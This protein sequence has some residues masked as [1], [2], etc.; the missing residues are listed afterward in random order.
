MRRN[1]RW[2]SLLCLAGILLGLAGCGSRPVSILDEGADRF[3]QGKTVEDYSLRNSGD[4]LD[5]L[6]DNYSGSFY[7]PSE[8]E[9]SDDEYEE[10]KQEQQG[11]PSWTDDIPTVRSRD[12]LVELVYRKYAEPATDLRFNVDGGYLP[13]LSDELFYVYCMIE[14]KDPIVGTGVKSW[15]WW[16]Q[17][18]EY[19]L[20]I[21]YAFPLDELTRMRTEARAKAGEVAR[22]LEKP[23]MSDYE[24]VVAVNEYL[25]DTVYYPPNEPYADVTHSAYG[26]LI[27]GCAVCEG[28]ACACQAILKEMNGACDLVIGPCT[29]GEYHA[30]NLAMVDGN[31]YQLDVT[32][33]DGS[34]QRDAYLLVT[35]AYMRQSRS[36]DYALYPSTP[37]YPY[38]P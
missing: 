12:E 20:G 23:G 2:I 31:W 24:R 29:N 15:L 7:S 9:L 28:Y 6:I 17:G 35:D 4:L 37:A 34:N 18:N 27:D 19:Y 16:N 10:K 26:A 8:T 13:D 1:R 21:E 25:C 22:K 38:T 33:N 32:W 30:W 3:S 14:R 11:D 36:W 5:E